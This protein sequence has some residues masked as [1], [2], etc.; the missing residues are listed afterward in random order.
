[1]RKLRIISQAFFLFVFVFLFLQTESKGADKLGYP[2]RVFLDFDPLLFLASLLSSRHIATGFLLSLVLVV[3][4]VFMGRIF[5]GWICP[6]GTLNNIA[7]SFRRSPPT[8]LRRNWYRA[9]YYILLFLLASSLFTAQI[10]GLLDPL[11]LLVRSLTLAVYPLFNYITRTFFDTIYTLH[12][13]ILVDGSEFIY[14]FLQRTLLSFQQPLF[15]QGMF[16]GLLFFIILGLNLVEKRFW[17]KYLCP[18]GA[19]LGI[20]SR[21]ALVHRSVSEGC[22]SCGL[23]EGIC[24]GNTASDNEKA[25]RNTECML[26]MDCDD[27]CPHNAVTFGFTIK[28]KHRAMDLG[29]RNTVRALLAGMFAVPLLRIVPSPRSGHAARNLIRPPGSH[30]E[31]EFLARCIRCGECMKVCIT[32]GL[33]PTLFEAGLEGLWTPMLVPQRGYCEYRCT[34]CGQ[35][36]PTGAIRQLTLEEKA[37]TKIGL[38]VIDKG[39][40]LPYSFA[41]PC[42]VCEEMCPTADKAIRLTSVTVTDRSGNTILLQQ[43]VI[44][45]SK[46]IG[47]GICEAH[48]PVRSKPAIYVL[49]TG[50]SR[51]PQNQAVLD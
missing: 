32:N 51:S 2:V 15:F 24:S 21:Y 1:M 41:T 37:H 22:T 25:W 7:G 29:K 9:K 43:P 8:L 11:S 50:E 30:A 4:T 12:I 48:C 19:L 34:L 27:L 3:I 40:C 47:C 23:C 49:S 28:K 39:R 13:P 6:L 10:A 31:K 36:C 35:V 18:L 17:C 38:A 33:Q 45:A 44:D 20:L 14:G 5:C 46:C 26:C 16:V 42:I